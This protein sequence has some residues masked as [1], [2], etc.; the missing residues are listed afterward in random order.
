[1]LGGHICWG[2]SYMLGVSYIY[3]R[4]GVRSWREGIG[5]AVLGRWIEGA[6][7]GWMDGWMWVC[8]C[9]DGWRDADD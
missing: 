4:H 8:T 5:E 7:N 2:V 1:M 6:I 9:I 3:S